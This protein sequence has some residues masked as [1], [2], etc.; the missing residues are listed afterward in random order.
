M[1]K[2]RASRVSKKQD[3]LFWAVINIDV[4]V[5]KF[6]ELERGGDLTIESTM[7]WDR[8]RIYDSRDLSAPKHL[9][10]A[11]RRQAYAIRRDQRQE[12]VL[13]K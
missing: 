4:F 6:V 5:I 13:V 1:D 9:R 2:P 7:R 3:N 11:A 10:D 8:S 12:K